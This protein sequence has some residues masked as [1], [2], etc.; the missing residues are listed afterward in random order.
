MLDKHKDEK[1]QLNPNQHITT[2]TI[3]ELKIYEDASS[4]NLSVQHI[5]YNKALK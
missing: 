1:L 3:I 4:E 2:H 5:K